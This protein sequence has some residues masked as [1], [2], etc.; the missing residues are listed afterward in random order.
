MIEIFTPNFGRLALI[1]K[2]CR[3]E[4]SRIRGLF[5]PFKPL[6]FGWTGKGELPILT[7][8]E[9]TEFCPQLDV[10]GVVCGYYLNELTLKLLHRHD[11]HQLLYNKYQ[12][13]V[14]ELLDKQNRH[15][16]LRIFEKYLLQEIGFGLVLGHDAE[17]GETITATRHYQYLPQKGPVVTQPLNGEQDNIIFGA[18]LIALQKEKFESQQEHLQAQRLTRLLIDIQL[19][20]KELRSRRVMQEIKQYKAQNT[21]FPNT[22]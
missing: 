1:A 5:L 7:S 16:I 2:G 13:A 17:S 3:R 14:F 20:G 15:T 21:P 9:Q 6:L 11:P 8:I 12:Y 19:S 22:A 18:T 4:K 10:L